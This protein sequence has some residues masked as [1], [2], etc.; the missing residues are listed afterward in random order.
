MKF[1]KKIN[2]GDIFDARVGSIED[3]GAFLHLRFPD[4]TLVSLFKTFFFLEHMLIWV[5][6]MRY[7][8]LLIHDKTM[9][10]VIIISLVLYMSQRCRGIWF[11]T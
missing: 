6:I 4:G 7:G 10:Q 2:V 11:K 1:S 5:H 9:M 8:K 3:Y